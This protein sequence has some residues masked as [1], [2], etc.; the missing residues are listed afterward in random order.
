MSDLVLEEEEKK[1][2]KKKK[3]GRHDGSSGMRRAF[4]QNPRSLGV[5]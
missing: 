5:P 2:K 1:N 4:A 3:K